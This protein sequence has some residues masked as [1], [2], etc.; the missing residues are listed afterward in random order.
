L[1]GLLGVE[2]ESSIGCIRDSDVGRIVDPAVVGSE[3][4]DGRSERLFGFFGDQIAVD[5]GRGD[6]GAADVEPESQVIGEDDAN[7]QGTGDLEGKEDIPAAGSVIVDGDGGR[8]SRKGGS[9]D[10]VDLTGAGFEDRGRRGRDEV[11]V[12]GYELGHAGF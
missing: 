2:G 5:V 6:H 7:R 1:I 4:S 11:G 10:S 12:V 8:S 9:E 3:I